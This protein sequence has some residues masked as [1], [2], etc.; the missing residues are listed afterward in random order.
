MAVMMREE[1]VKREEEEVEVRRGDQKSL[2]IELCGGMRA[3]TV[4]VMHIHQ[5]GMNHGALT[6]RRGGSESRAV[7]S[8]LRLTYVRC[9]LSRNRRPRVWQFMPNE[10]YRSQGSTRGLILFRPKMSHYTSPHWEVLI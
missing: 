8:P 6:Q 2:S 10:I 1:K 7:L 5:A 9:R 3:S 4:K